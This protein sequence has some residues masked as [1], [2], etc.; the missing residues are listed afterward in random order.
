MADL[1]DPQSYNIWD[2]E[3]WSKKARMETADRAEQADFDR[4]AKLQQ[5]LRKMFSADEI[6]RLREQ[7][8]LEEKRADTAVERG[9]GQKRREMEA[10]VSELGE[11]FGLLPSVLAGK[12]LAPREQAIIASRA[13]GFSQYRQALTQAGGIPRSVELGQR[14]MAQDVAEAEA[15]E[16][17][18]KVRSAAARGALNFAE[19]EE[20]MR[21]MGNISKAALFDDEN[22]MTR[23][24][25]EADRAR[26]IKLDEAQIGLLKAQAVKAAGVGGAGGFLDA[27]GK[28]AQ[29]PARI[30]GGIWNDETTNVTPGR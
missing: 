30:R 19:A 1:R 3:R 24:S 10:R 21:R 26:K 17:E 9:L 23:K 15:G 28:E 11:A 12:E 6:A 14:G 5:E 8:N 22:I 13:P 7:Y 25:L 18:A 29:P 16:G 2:K 20:R 4:R 27:L